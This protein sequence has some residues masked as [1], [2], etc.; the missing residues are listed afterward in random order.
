MTQLQCGVIQV[1]A[2]MLKADID[3]KQEPFLSN[4]ITLFQCCKMKEVKN[5]ARVLL[6]HG[7]QLIGIL[8]E[9]GVLEYGEL[10]VQV[11]D[12]T[13]PTGASKRVVTGTVL[14]AKMP[15]VHPGD[16]RVLE[17]V[18]I[19]SLH[20]YNDVVVFPQKGER[21]HTHVRIRFLLLFIVFIL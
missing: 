14:L 11:T 9:S 4:I 16:V 8:D 12:P 15:A 1:L 20:H 10:F 19:P 13:D 5:K 21:P 6:D 3:I 18:D 2:N 7:A 17:C